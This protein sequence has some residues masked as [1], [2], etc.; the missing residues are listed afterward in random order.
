MGSRYIVI[1][2]RLGMARSNLELL[3]LGYRIHKPIK[4]NVVSIYAHVWK[5]KSV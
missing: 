1:M 5:K 4:A 2:M 3:F